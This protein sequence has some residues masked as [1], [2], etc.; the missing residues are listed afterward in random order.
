MPI[1]VKNI[2]KKE[3]IIPNPIAR[4]KLMK[5][6]GQLILTKKMYLPIVRRADFMNLFGKEQLPLR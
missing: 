4:K 5:P 2:T 1:M 3:S 6:L